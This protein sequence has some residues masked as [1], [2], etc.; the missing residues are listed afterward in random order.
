[1]SCPESGATHVGFV[2][3]TIRVESRYTVIKAMLND[4][5]E[6]KCLL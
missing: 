3:V 5:S 4:L 2:N 6:T 1:M